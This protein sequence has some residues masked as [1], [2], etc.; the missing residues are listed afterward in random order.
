MGFEPVFGFGPHRAVKLCFQHIA[1]PVLP[2]QFHA[3]A[4]RPGLCGRKGNARIHGGFCIGW[5]LYPHEFPGE[6]EERRLLAPG[7]ASSARMGIGEPAVTCILPPFVPALLHSP[8]EGLPDS[9]TLT[10]V[11]APH[12]SIRLTCTA[13]RRVWQKCHRTRFQHP[14]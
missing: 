3:A 12:R 4:Q 8:G 1:E 13:K 7:P 6:V 2:V 9:T 14:V 10:G 5:R 11:I